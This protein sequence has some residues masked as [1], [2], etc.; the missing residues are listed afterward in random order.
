[1]KNKII[2]AIEIMRD[3]A[4]RT[5]LTSTFE[6]P[7]RYLWTDALAVCNFLQP[8]KITRDFGLA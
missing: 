3:Y 7:N 6:V 8:F 2:I 4:S 1:M 5:G